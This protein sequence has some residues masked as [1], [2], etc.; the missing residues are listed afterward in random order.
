MRTTLLVPVPEARALLDRVTGAP[1]DPHVT[2]AFPFLEAEAVTDGVL[3]ALGGRV[4]S[5]S[6]FAFSLSTTVRF[7]EVVFLSPDP[8]EPFRGLVRAL[9]SGEPPYDMPVTDIWPHVTV[10]AP[11]AEVERVRADL[12]PALPMACRAREV[13]LRVDNGIGGWRVMAAFDLQP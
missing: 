4:A 6:A 10:V 11:A 9:G 12:E 3:A 8:A 5:V 13:Q 1:S 2:L 7:G